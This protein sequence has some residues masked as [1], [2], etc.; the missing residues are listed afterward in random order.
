MT[1]TEREQISAAIQ[2]TR[3][4][5][6]LFQANFEIGVELADLYESAKPVHTSALGIWSTV[7]DL[8]RAQKGITK[9]TDDAINLDELFGQK[10]NTDG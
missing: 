6:D 4:E 5:L 2:R 7:V 9:D 3:E 1:A 8:L 10:E